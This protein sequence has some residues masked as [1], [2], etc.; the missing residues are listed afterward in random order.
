M[1][2][3]VGKTSWDRCPTHASGRPDTWSTAGVREGCPLRRDRWLEGDDRG[4]RGPRSVINGR[5]WPADVCMSP[6]LE[7]NRRC[8]GKLLSG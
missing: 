3:A 6:D 7:D 2:E 5:R 1:E 4:R 8:E